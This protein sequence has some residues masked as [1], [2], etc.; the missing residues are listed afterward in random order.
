MDQHVFIYVRSHLGTEAELL[1]DLRQTVEDR[2]D[3]VLANPPTTSLP[4]DNPSGANTLG[5][6]GSV[7]VENV[8]IT[9]PCYGWP[10]NLPPEGDDGDVLANTVLQTRWA[11][12]EERRC[13][14]NL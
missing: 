5:R 14:S 1:H 8:F 11:I 10:A 3:T 2:G 6:T 9:R 4:I 13:P 7:M 12:L